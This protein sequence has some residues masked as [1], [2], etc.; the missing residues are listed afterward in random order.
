MSANTS[1]T[2]DV[3]K[4]SYQQLLHVSDTDGIHATTRRL[5]YDGDGTATCLSIST[6]SADIDGDFIAGTLT[7]DGALTVAGAISGVTDLTM[8]GTLAMS[9]TKLINWASGSVTLG[10]TAANTMTVAG[11]TAWDMGAVAT[12]DFDGALNITTASSDIT[13]FSGAAGVDYSLIFNGETND[14]SIKYMEDEDRFDFDNDVD[15]IGNLTA[16]TIQTD[17]NLTVGAT[18]ADGVLP[19]LSIIGDADADGA[20]TTSETFSLVL[21]PIATPTDA[22]WTFASSQGKGYQFDKSIFMTEQASAQTDLAG[23]GQFWVRNDAPNV[24]MFTND[25]G[26]DF[27]IS[28]GGTGH[29]SMYWAANGTPITP[30]TAAYPMACVNLTTGSLLTGFTFVASSTGVIA[31]V[32]DGSG[33]GALTCN[34]VGHGLVTGDVIVVEGMAVDAHNGVTT[35]TRITDD[36]FSCDDITHSSGTGAGVWDEPDYLLVSADGAGE[37]H[38]TYT[39]SVIKGAGATASVTFEP[40]V[41]ST[42][43]SEAII[44]RQIPGTD[45]GVVA[46]QSFETLAVGDRIFLT[47]TNETNTNTLQFKYGNIVLTRF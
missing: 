40:Y 32:V 5:V 39:A 44:Q 14:G 4:Q 1:L 30:Q 46:G 25:A 34:D 37:Y 19:V 36:Q 22:Y 43:C 33:S 29:A 38:F 21:T 10:E 18:A 31:S 24:P 20:A 12:L 23:D 41:N 13:L 15:V 42:V 6:A 3:V 8:S 35:V 2:G 17:T 28:L 9:T 16:S 26:T 11:A 47:V 27:E 45:Q 7:S